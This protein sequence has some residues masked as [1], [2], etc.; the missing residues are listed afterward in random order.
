MNVE[1]RNFTRIEFASRVELQNSGR[2]LQSELLDISL[3]GALISRPEDWQGAPGTEGC[4]IIRLG[5]D[6][7]V[8]EMQGL[9]VH[10]DDERIGWKCTSIDLDSITHLRR[11][12]EYNLG[13]TE[14]LHREIGELIQL[15]DDDAV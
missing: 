9:A 14:V 1:R 15:P 5:S 2:R 3:K 7:D 12:I 4:L 10:V 13:D 8:I 11:L 6:D